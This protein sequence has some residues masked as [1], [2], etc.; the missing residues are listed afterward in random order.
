MTEKLN[1]CPF[2]GGEADFDGHSESCNA[3]CLKCGAIGPRSHFDPED[4]TQIEESERE[5][6]AGWNARAALATPTTNVYTP[7]RFEACHCIAGGCN[8]ACSPERGGGGPGLVAATCGTQEPQP[9][10]HFEGSPQE[11][12]VQIFTRLCMPAVRG[13]DA[14]GPEFVSRL[15]G[16]FFGALL[17]TMA[18]DYGQEATAALA[19][20]LVD[21]FASLPLDGSNGR[22]H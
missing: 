12:G 16:G 22:A 2:C 17:G 5:A 1:P 3:R 6:R 9:A 8:G 19:H 4:D 20:R 7:G 10:M 11:I 14:A 18:A 15:Y 21:R 13:F